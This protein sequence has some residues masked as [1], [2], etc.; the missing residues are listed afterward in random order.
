MSLAWLR[1]NRRQ[2]VRCGVLRQALQVELIAIDDVRRPDSS[3]SVLK[4]YTVE[5]GRPTILE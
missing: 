1:Q 5:A 3:R 2:L 4:R